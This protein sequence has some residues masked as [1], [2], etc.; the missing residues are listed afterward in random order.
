MRA[1][2]KF[3]MRVLA[4]FFQYVVVLWLVVAGVAI[5]AFLFPFRGFSTDLGL[6]VGLYVL[7][8]G[9]FW[10]LSRISTGRWARQSR[11]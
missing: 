11:R 7:L 4:K 9:L 8:G 2:A 5:C 1:L 6:A 3:F 10:V